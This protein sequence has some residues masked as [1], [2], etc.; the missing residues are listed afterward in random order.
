MN[1]KI[2]VAFIDEVLSKTIENETS[3][4]LRLKY[5]LD[6]SMIKSAKKL[7]IEKANNIYNKIFPLQNKQHDECFTIHDNKMLFWFNDENMSTKVLIHQ[8][9]NDLF[10]L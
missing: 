8:L 2:N 6:D 4:S 3:N 9:N 1:R 10:E 5:H 7:L